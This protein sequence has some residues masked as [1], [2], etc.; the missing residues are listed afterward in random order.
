MG[1]CKGSGRPPWEVC[2]YPGTATC[3]PI[4]DYGYLQPPPPANLQVVKEAM[5]FWCN[6]FR[7]LCLGD[8]NLLL[9]PVTDRHGDPLATQSQTWSAFGYLVSEFGWSDLWRVFNP[10]TRAYSWSIPSRGRLSRID[11][12]L[13]N[14]KFLTKLS[15]ITYLPRG[16]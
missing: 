14:D 3:T 1:V 4:C 10:N 6:V 9:D 11:L 13:G 12:A 7:S 5:F 8:F 15:S 2:L 16:V